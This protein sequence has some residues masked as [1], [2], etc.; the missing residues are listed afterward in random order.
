MELRQRYQLTRPGLSLLEVVLIIGVVA[1]VASFSVRGYAATQQR[2][3]V[4][5]EANQ[6][7]SALRE[8]QS[9]AQTAQSSQG[10]NLTCDGDVLRLA[11]L[12]GG[13]PETTVLNAGIT[14]DA[15]NVSFTKL[16]GLPTSSASFTL[17]D[18]GQAVR[19]VDVS[20]GG[21]VTTLSL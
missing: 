11:P 7:V 15:A 18:H 20:S 16:T 12:S 21:V 1:I 14:C 19:R 9:R 5:K 6:L 4:T 8:A 13:T 3:R 17:R 2:S 10:W